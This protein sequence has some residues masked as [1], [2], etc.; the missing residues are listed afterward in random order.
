MVIATH[1]F[2]KMD[3]IT[4]NLRLLAEFGQMGVQLFF[5]ASAY[6]LCLSASKP[7]TDL[8]PN[9]S[10]FLRRFFRIAPMYYI[11]IL[12]YFTRH[13]VNQFEVWPEFN[14]DPYTLKNV[15][16]NIFFVH[17]FTPAAVSSIVPG[18]WSIATE[19]C[20]YLIF[21]SLFLFCKNLKT[22]FGEHSLFILSIV[23]LVCSV[24]IALAASFFSGKPFK[25]N[26]FLYFSITTQLP[27]FLI[28]M[29]TFFRDR[30]HPN[31]KILLSAPAF[32]LGCVISFTLLRRGSGP[33][34]VLAPYFAAIAFSH[35][36]PLLRMF[37]RN[38][39][40]AVAKIGEASYSMYILHWLFLPPA[41]N[42]YRFSLKAGVPAFLSGAAVFIGTVA[43][44]Y[45]FARLTAHAIENRGIAF[46]HSVGAALNNQKAYL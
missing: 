3:G 25:N 26:G 10:F 28:G 5:V 17:G 8:H 11:A 32:F 23:A 30:T 19:M 37:V 40:G 43:L 35:L 16:A 42:L 18:G 34:M 22:R 15:A 46:G 31:P 6:T 7:Q 21:P 12:I 41:L 20:F 45:F 36:L 33:A 44:T 1:L 9:T 13:V 4:N 14:I 2:S 39:S 29:A 24:L 38:K 27:V